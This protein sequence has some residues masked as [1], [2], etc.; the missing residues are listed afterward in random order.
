MLAGARAAL[1]GNFVGLYLRGSLASGDFIPETS[2]VDLLAA[3]ERPVGDAEFEALAALHERLAA[4]PNPY[5][6]RVEIAYVERAALRRFRPGLSHPTRGQGDTLKQTEHHT[7]WILERWALREYG[8]ALAGPDP[9]TLIDPV[10]REEVR[11]AVRA[12]LRYWGE[13]A[14]T[15]D[16]PEWRAPRRAAATYV[17]ETMCRALYT[18]DRGEL[19]S[20]R[21]AV[22]WAVEALPEPW[23]GLA[24]RSQ[25]WR[26]DDTHDRAIAAGVLGFVLWAASVQGGSSGGG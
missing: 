15:L 16:E 17:V 12:R 6:R 1:G 9:R 14:R 11:G 23:R 8:V 19:S 24:A 5:G 13:W 25:K 4:R 10:T 3:T 20:K 2:D 22:A 26:T 21:R 7:N 18:L